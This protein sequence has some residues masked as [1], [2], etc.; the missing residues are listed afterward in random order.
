MLV[1][2]LFGLLARFCSVLFGG[3]GGLEAG[4]GFARFEGLAVLGGE[5]VLINRFDVGFGAV[6][7]VLVETVLRIFG[8]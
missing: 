8:G 1:V 3:L 6:A 7:D 4:E 2:F 5:T